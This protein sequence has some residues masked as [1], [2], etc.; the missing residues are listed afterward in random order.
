MKTTTAVRR[1]RARTQCKRIWAPVAKTEQINGYYHE[2]RRGL[3]PL[4]RLSRSSAPRLGAAALAAAHYEQGLPI[5]APTLSQ[6]AF[7]FRT[8][9]AAVQKARNGHRKA[10][11]TTLAKH[12]AAS[13]PA[14]FKTVNGSMS[15]YEILADDVLIAALSE[16]LLGARAH[17]GGG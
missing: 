3:N 13:S 16:R 8:S 2:R 12:L 4:G 10:K 6:V 5:A 11:S 9:L 17:N 1:D 15:S 14:E 7:A